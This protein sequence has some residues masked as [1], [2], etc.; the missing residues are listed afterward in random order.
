MA[1]AAV[2]AA[3]PFSDPRLDQERLDITISQT[4]IIGNHGIKSCLITERQLLVGDNDI[5]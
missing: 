5:F 4:K 3:V 2:D 1:A